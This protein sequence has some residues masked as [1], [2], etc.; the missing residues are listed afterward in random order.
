MIAFWILAAIPA[1]YLRWRF[2]IPYVLALMGSDA[3]IFKSRVLTYLAL[4]LLRSAKHVLVVSEALRALVLDR[5]RIAPTKV[6]V[7]QNGV[8]RRR[9]SAAQL[10]AFA[11]GR[12]LSI[13]IPYLLSVATLRPM[14]RIELLIELVAAL[15]SH[16]LVLCGKTDLSAYVEQLRRQAEALHCASRVHFIG[17][18]P[19]SEVPA[20]LQIAQFYVTASSW[21]GQPN[22]VLE[23][24]AAGVPVCA[25]DI[26]AHR[27]LVRD[28]ETGVLFTP[29]DVKRAAARIAAL[30]LDSKTRG[31]MA[32]RAAA[33]IPARSW[34]ECARKYLD[35]TW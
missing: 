7:V 31:Q 23:A 11:T 4:P 8:S 5:C 18:V 17:A 30:H 21:E 2:G 26:P 34:E 16:H 32:E 13:E 35:L 29:A 24:I 9:L 14:K 12:G 20:F 33:N 28:G 27:E 22:A 19:P 10:Q 6:V 3:L 25:S 1:L 15:P